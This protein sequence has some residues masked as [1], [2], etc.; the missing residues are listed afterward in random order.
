MAYRSLEA[1]RIDQT[2]ETL[3]KRIDERFP[4]RG[5]S[6][7]CG[8]LLAIAREDAP[9]IDLMIARAARR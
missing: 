1:D 3:K 8:E 6:R 7:L 4:E 9:A 5:I 2:I